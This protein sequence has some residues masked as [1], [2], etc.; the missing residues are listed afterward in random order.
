MSLTVT[1]RAAALELARKAVIGVAAARL[2]ETEEDAAL[3]LSD[4]RE[5]CEA[6]GVSN[7]VCWALLFSSAVMGLTDAL[8]DLAEIHHQSPSAELVDF[9]LTQE[10]L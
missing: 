9:A 8:V 2:T 3:I 10:A 7:A 6:L 5:Q 1:Q 4:Y